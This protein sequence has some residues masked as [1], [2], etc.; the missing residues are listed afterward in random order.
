MLRNKKTKCIAFSQKTR[1]IKD[2]ATIRLYGNDLPWVDEVDHLGCT[3]QSD[4]KMTSDIRRKRGKFIGK[5]N[6]ILQE[7]HFSPPEVLMKVIES[8]A[9]SF[10]GSPIWNLTSKDVDKIFKSW[11]VMLRKVFNLD[12]CTHRYLLEDITNTRHV[13]PKLMA[14]T[15][16]FYESLGNSPKPGIRFLFGVSTGDNR[17][18]TGQ[19]TTKITKLCEG[20]PN[21]ATIKRTAKYVPIPPEES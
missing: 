18:T 4:V 8:Q 7:L 16:T 3:L 1:E 20:T 14:K 17:T 11:N 19:N 12:R 5:V 10:F 13:L 6:S 9:T 21:K 2:L 15:Q